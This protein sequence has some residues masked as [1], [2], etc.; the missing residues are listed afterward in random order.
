M[1]GMLE[2]IA[3]DFARLESD[4]TAAEEAAADEYKNLKNTS[5]VRFSIPSL[6]AS[7]VTQRT[8]PYPRS[9]RC[10]VPFHLGS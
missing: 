7:I 5:E 2:V 3:S 9:S 6:Q 10:V 8:T 4:T 1:V